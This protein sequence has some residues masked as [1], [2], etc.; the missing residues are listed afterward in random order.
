MNYPQNIISFLKSVSSF[1][2]E[3][4]NDFVEKGKGIEVAKGEFL[5]SAQQTCRSFGFIHSGTFSFLLD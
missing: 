3:E 1:T 5:I 2:D 4:I